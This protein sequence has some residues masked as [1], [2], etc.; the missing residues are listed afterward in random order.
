MT[1]PRIAAA[2]TLAL[3]CGCAGVPA[4]RVA[5]PVVRLRHAID[6]AMTWRSHAPPHDGIFGARPL[7]DGGRATPAQAIARAI[8]HTNLRLAPPDAMAFAL[9]TVRAAS[10]N[11]L[12]AEFLGATLLQESAYD[13]RAFSSAGAIGIAQFMPGTAADWNVD[14]SDP[15]AAIAGAALLLGDYVRTY[16]HTDDPYSLAMAAYNAGPGAVAAYDGVPPYPETR[17]YIA[18]I[19]DR[20]VQIYAYESGLRRQGSGLFGE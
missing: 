10:D 13:P 12:P 20:E 7:V 3:L 5:R 11:G 6:V 1:Y 17:A 16:R 14:P 19:D 15:M 9:R 2:V 8:L 18:D 4:P